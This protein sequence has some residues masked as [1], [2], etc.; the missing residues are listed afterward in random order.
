MLDDIIAAL[1]P[2][3]IINI[4]YLIIYAK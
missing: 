4:G 1:P 3:I 2:V